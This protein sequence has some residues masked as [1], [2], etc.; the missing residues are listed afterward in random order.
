LYLKLIIDSNGGRKVDATYFQCEV[1]TPPHSRWQ[2]PPI[3]LNDAPTPM[4][5]NEQ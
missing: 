1:G 3:D 5:C 4:T 2:I